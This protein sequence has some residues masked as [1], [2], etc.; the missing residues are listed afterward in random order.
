VV[1]RFELLRC[2]GKGGMGVV[3]LARDSHADT[4]FRQDGPLIEPT[5]AVFNDQP[6]VIGCASSLVALKT[7]RPELC[8]NVRAVEYFRKEAVYMQQLQHPSILR[9]LEFCDCSDGSYLTMPYMERG[10]LYR[11]IQQGPLA[12]GQLIHIAKQIACALHY[13]H[14]RGIV[15]RDLKPQN[16]LLDAADN[17]YLTDF[18]LCQSLLHN[19]PVQPGNLD[20]TASYLS[21]MRAR[22]EYDDTRT[23]IYAFG[24]L[25]YEMLTGQAPYVGA[26]DEVLRAIEAGPPPPIR[27]LSPRAPSCLLSIVEGAMA[28]ELHQRYAHMS[29]LLADIER[30]QKHFAP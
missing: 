22:G 5:G 12:E 14:S 24:A 11:L 23:D 2:I 18:G 28:R 30:A 21:P 16:I 10:S 20:G 26:R 6:A 29:Y 17:A 19:S 7:L 15:H 4:A 27:K 1:G 8:G 25:L 3:Y 13:A 9:V